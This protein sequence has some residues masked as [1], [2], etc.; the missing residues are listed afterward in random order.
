MFGM[1]MMVALAAIAAGPA[2]PVRG[3]A[4]AGD[5]DSLRIGETR[6]RLHGID[7]PELDQTCT[8]PGASWACGSEAASQLAK[9]VTGRDVLCLPMGEDQH[10]RV[11]AR[12][13]VMGRDINQAMVESGYALAF[14]RYGTEYVAAEER[15]KAAK[16]GLWSGSFQTPSE[17]RSADQ[18]REVRS[19][20]SRRTVNRAPSGSAPRGCVIKGNQSRR[21]EWIYHLPGMPYY[22]QTRA[23]AMFCSEAE[24]R[25]AG[26][27]RAI[28]R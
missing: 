1:W 17:F 9:L 5:G 10:G 18:S 2:E 21:G 6:I 20:G 26:Y 16:R 8:R 22:D 27:R 19:P 13:K 12:C 11:L 14:R 24:A 25:A 3:L 7:A 28:V 23:E 15:A 4:I